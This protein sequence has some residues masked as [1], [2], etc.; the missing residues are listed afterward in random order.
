MHIL[1]K[2]YASMLLRN[3]VY[4]KENYMGKESS[5]C[6]KSQEWRYKGCFFFTKKS[7]WDIIVL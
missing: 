1:R 7:G 4:T 2:Q 5:F 6:T 3:W